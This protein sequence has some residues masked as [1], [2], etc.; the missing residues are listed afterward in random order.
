MRP[1]SI[2]VIGVLYIIGGALAIWDVV[3]G[4]FRNHISI[5]LAVCLLFVGY[6]VLPDFSVK[7]SDQEIRGPLR[8]AIGLGFPVLL[9]VFLAFRT[10]GGRFARVFPCRRFHQNNYLRH[11]VIGLALALMTYGFY[12]SRNSYV[13]SAGQRLL[14]V[15]LRVETWRS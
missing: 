10:S 5:N 4:L 8:A 14:L 7:W 9:A 6:F 12:V 2:T 13:I 11:S 1:R 3:S 15:P